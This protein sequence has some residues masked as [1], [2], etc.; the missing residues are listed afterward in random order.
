M[1]IKIKNKSDDSTG[2]TKRH[3]NGKL[4]VLPKLLKLKVFMINAFS[5][6]KTTLKK[7]KKIPLQLFIILLL[8][9]YVLLS[10]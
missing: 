2:K 1:I 6:A 10:R 4:M 7:I 8:C 9:F 5:K 3:I